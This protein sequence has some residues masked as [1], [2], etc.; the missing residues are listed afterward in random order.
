LIAEAQEEPVGSR[1]GAVA[2][3]RAN[4]LPSLSVDGAS[5]A[6][7]SLRFQSPP[8]RTGQADLPH[9][10]HPWASSSEVMVPFGRCALS[11]ATGPASTW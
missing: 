10:A 11:R 3:R 6:S 2:C 4:L 7:P 9:P 5:L 1:T 8:H